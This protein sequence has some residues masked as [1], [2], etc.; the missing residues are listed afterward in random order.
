MVGRRVS[1]AAALVCLV[2]AIVAA[3]IEIVRDLPRGLMAIA[4]LAA[5]VVLAWQAVLR[6]G[7][8]RDVL[9]AGGGLLLLAAVV[10]VLSGDSFGFGLAAIALLILGVAIGRRVFRA[11]ATLQ[12][13]TPP[14]RAVVVWNPRSGGGKAVSNNLAD[15][16]PSIPRPRTARPRRGGRGSRRTGGR[17]R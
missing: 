6:R 4:L 2:A 5:G 8:T 1:A 13:A 16:A 15:E 14:R 3:A 17:R 10:V 7:A 12:A 11:A 9:V